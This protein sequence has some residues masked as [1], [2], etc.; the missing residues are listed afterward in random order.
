[1]RGSTHGD[2]LILDA[3]EA[4]ANATKYGLAAAVISSDAARCERVA[5][6]M[7]TGL[8]WVNCSQ[9]CFPQ[10]PWGGKVGRASGHG[11]DLG[12]AGL[13]AYLDLKSVV[14]Y[15]SADKWDWYPQQHKSKL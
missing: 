13:D 9:P 2:G 7:R 3:M 10:L 1:M 6:R 14:T 12:E 11:R 15:T 8:V 4:V 5:R